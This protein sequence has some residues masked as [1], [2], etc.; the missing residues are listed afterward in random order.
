MKPEKG[1]TERRREKAEG[2]IQ[3]DEKGQK[4]KHDKLGPHLF[5]FDLQKFSKE[6]FV[7]CLAT[8]EEG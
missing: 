2:R 6:K 5:V 7:F 8:P 4:I 1:G 3:K